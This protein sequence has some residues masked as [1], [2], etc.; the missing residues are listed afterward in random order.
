MLRRGLRVAAVVG[1]PLCG[2]DRLLCLDRKSVRLHVLCCASA[3]FQR[4]LSLGDLDYGRSWR[5]IQRDSPTRVGERA[6]L[7]TRFGRGPPIVARS[8]DPGPKPDRRRPDD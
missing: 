2:L 6:H 1:E 5:E 3:W 4:N 7:T 8:P